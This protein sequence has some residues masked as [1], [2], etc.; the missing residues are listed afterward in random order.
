MRVIGH[1]GAAACA[2]ENTLPG[3]QAGIALGA[4]LVEVD[5]QLSS[6]GEA[7]LLHDD[8]LSR[9]TDVARV[10]GVRRGAPARPGAFT[11][12]E[13]ARLDAGSWGRWRGS[14]F[15]GAPVPTLRAV[16][17]LLGR[18]GRVGI[19]VELKC[20][21]ASPGVEHVVADLLRA[22]QDGGARPPVVVHSF[23]LAAM[24]R[25]AGVA[26]QRGVRCELGVARN[27]RFPLRHV[28]RLPHGT[29]SIN[30]WHRA[31]GPAYV[32]A[33]HARGLRTYPFTVNDPRRMAELAGLGVDGLVTD[34]PDVLRGLL[35][36]LEG[37][38][39]AP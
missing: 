36:A 33:L 30:P 5:V 19:L 38:Q 3:I 9:T 32:R 39:A 15:A 27:R 28:D 23:D 18:D 13:L 8:D 1:R 11:A 22:W 4:D 25:F 26:A 20:P 12:A 37:A 2:P 7:V 16:L 35:D 14:A 10:Y 24:G 6:D 34:R 17:D 31:L 21:A 29:T